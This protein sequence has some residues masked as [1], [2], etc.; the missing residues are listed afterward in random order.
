M[1]LKK[2]WHWWRHLDQNPI[3][4]RERGGW[5]TPNPFYNTLQR[6]SPFLVIA[7]VLFGSCAAIS[8]AAFTS[9]D[10]NTVA[11]GLLICLPAVV[12]YALTLFS[13]LMAPA[14]TAP[15][16]SMEVDRGT[17]EILR[18][19]PYSTHAILLAK[20]FGALGRLR[21]WFVL[22][23]LSGIQAIAITCFSLADERLVWWGW[24]MGLAV[25]LRPFLEIVFAGVMG[26]YLST[27]VR[28]ATTALAGS[29]TAVFAMKL[30]NGTATWAWFASSYNALTQSDWPIITLSTTI[31]PTAGY[32]LALLLLMMG[33]WRQANFLD[34]GEAAYSTQ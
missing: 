1:N 14:L 30:L 12:S 29:Y 2:A 18:L 13:T 21:V 16:I 4:Q 33:L 6:Y 32:L 7:A 11:F 23:V 8:N 22:L 34:Q 9:A 3:Y 25:M 19:T 15:I 27:W 31:G 26:L 10:S 28:S 20:L 17:W 24:L 5:G